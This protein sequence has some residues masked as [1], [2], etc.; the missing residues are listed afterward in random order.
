MIYFG[1][2]LCVILGLLMIFK[3]ESMTKLHFK[4]QSLFLKDASPTDTYLFITRI[5]G[6]VII[7]ICVILLILVFC[8]EL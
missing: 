1:I 6:S 4:I 5:L 7:L 8:G 2:I 3:P